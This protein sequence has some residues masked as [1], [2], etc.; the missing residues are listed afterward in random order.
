MLIEHGEQRLKEFST[1]AYP[2]EIVQISDR[3]YHITGYGHSNCTVIEGETSIILI[4]TL[5]SD[6]RS[7]MMIEDIQIFIRKPVQT[8][9]YTHG[10]PDHKGGAGTFR[11][12]VKE[13]IAFSNKQ[14]LL[15]YT[16]LLS[17][18]LHERGTHQ[19]GYDL[20]DEEAISQGIGIREG[21]VTAEGGYDFMEPTDVLTEQETTKVIDGVAMT[22]VAAPGE[23]GDTGLI[24]FPEDKVL[25]C[26][27]NYYSCFPNLYPIRGGQYRDI[28]QWIDSLNCMIAYDARAILPG[29]TKALVGKEEV[30]EVLTNYKNAIEYLLVNT[31]KAMD[32][33]LSIDEVVKAVQLPNELRA[34]PYLQELY[35]CVEW[36]VREIYVAYLGWFDGNPTNLH[37][38]PE[39]VHGEKMVQL[40]G[41]TAAVLEEIKRALASEEYQW[42]LELSDLLLSLDCMD[43]KQCKRKALIGLSEQETSANGRHYYLSYAKQLASMSS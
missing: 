1:T 9:I 6:I 35:G 25:C 17:N 3:I 19:H 38:L 28:S 4:D 12:T 20:S 2:K 18:V 42:V 16:E 29:H 15:K 33:S 34:L 30:T 23:C 24:W 41:G 13:I 39:A 14:P 40:M 43:A 26:G 37:R 27:D 8:I 10:N 22:F 11:D 21:M 7:K 32:I 5:D 31:L 36:T